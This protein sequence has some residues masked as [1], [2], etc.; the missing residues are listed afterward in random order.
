MHTV[1]K[2]GPPKVSPEKSLFLPWP[3]QIRRITDGD[4][5]RCT[6]KTPYGAPDLRDPPHKNDIYLIHGGNGNRVPTKAAIHWNVVDVIYAVV[7]IL[8]GTEVAD[9]ALLS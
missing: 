8:I 9:S 4:H 2:I 6:C 3:R 5:Y 1:F 7:V